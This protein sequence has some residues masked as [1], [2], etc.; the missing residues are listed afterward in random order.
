MSETINPRTSELR[1]QLSAVERASAA[2]IDRLSDR[3]AYASR[4]EFDE[5]R[6]LI[7]ALRQ[8][9]SHAR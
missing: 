8:L 5:I 1:V 9:G 3:A 7:K 2:L 6:S 4:E